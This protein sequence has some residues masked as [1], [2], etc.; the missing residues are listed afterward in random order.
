[1]VILMQCKCNFKINHYWN[2]GDT[3]WTGKWSE[4]N[5]DLATQGVEDDV[6]NTNY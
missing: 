3:Q 6:I 2:D 5:A 4:P 1:M